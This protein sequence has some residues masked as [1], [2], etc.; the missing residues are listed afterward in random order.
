[1]NRVLS[2]VSFSIIF[3]VS[4]EKLFK[5]P[6]VVVFMLKLPYEQMLQMIQTKSGLSSDDI[7]QKIKQKCDQ[8]SGL[9]SKEGAAHIIANELGIRLV[10]DE[11]PLKVNQVI[12]GLRSVE[13]VGKVSRVFG[14]RSFNVNGREGKVA[15]AVI[16][17]ET[18]TLRLTG[19]G[20]KAEELSVLKEGDVLR[21]VDAYV[22]ENNG[23]KELHLNDRSRVIINPPGITITSVSSAPIQEVTRKKISDLQDV[24]QNIEILGTIVQV[25]D[26]KYFERCPSCRK[27]IQQKESGYACEQHGIVKPDYAYVL[28]LIVDD[29]SGN[30]RCVF[31]TEQVQQ[32]TKKNHDEL[33]LGQQ[34]PE[35]FAAVKTDLLGEMVRCTGRTVMN[36]YFNRLEFNVTIVS[37]DVNP[38]DEIR[39]LQKEL[40]QKVVVSS[41]VQK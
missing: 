6:A 7:L 4:C 17:D 40:G 31:F 39:R 30:I 21:V 12:V 41:V 10:P 13:L 3:V 37:R 11:G 22:K 27:R 25:Y 26:I 28:N 14:L 16:A 19:W 38:E 34:A 1:M 23:A 33:L 5:P 15:S 8:L 2:S 9:I 32:L 36:S 24:Q 18:G 29:G 20:S 35:S